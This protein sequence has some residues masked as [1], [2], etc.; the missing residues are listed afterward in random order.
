MHTASEIRKQYLKE[1]HYHV[2][3]IHIILPES[4]EVFIQSDLPSPFPHEHPSPPFAAAAHNNFGIDYHT[5]KCATTDIP[6]H[7]DAQYNLYTMNSPP[8]SGKVALDR[9]DRK[10]TRLNSSH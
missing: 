8:V 6:S 3:L 2:I 9:K 5:E 4:G 10:S 1:N 7:Y